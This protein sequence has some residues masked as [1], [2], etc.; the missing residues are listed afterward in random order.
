VSVQRLSVHALLAWS[1]IALLTGRPVSANPVI[2]GPSTLVGAAV[3]SVDVVAEPADTVAVLYDPTVVR[4]V[5]LLLSPENLEF[6]DANPSAEQYVPGSVVID[7]VR[8]DQVGIRYKGSLGSFLGCT[9]SEDPFD[10]TGRKTCLKL[11]MKLKFD[12]YVSDQRFL[13]VK[14]LLLHAMRSDRSMLGER[15][16]YSLFRQ[17]GIA[18][19]R[20]AHVRV[21]VNG[22]YAGVFLLVE[23]VDGQFVRSRF[24]EGG[25]GNLYKE[26]WPLTA[27]PDY[28]RDGLRTNR[29]ENPS[30][31]RMVAFDQDIQN[32]ANDAAEYWLDL[33]YMMRYMAVD[34][35]IW[36]DDGIIHFYCDGSVCG[37][38]NFFFY[39]EVNR[40]R[41]WLIPWD[42]DPLFF[43]GPN[44]LTPPGDWRDLDPD[45][46]PV[47]TLPGLPLTSLNPA[48]DPLIS[49]LARYPELY[50]AKQQEF[51]EGPFARIAVE[52]QLDVWRE[53]IRGAVAEAH[54]IDP[55]HIAV[56]DW[57]A[58]IASKKAALA[59]A[60]ASLAADI[61][62]PEVS[63]GAASLTAL[64]VILVLRH[65][66]RRAPPRRSRGI[67]QRGVGSALDSAFERS[68]PQ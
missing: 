28:Y 21:V 15:L 27:D 7:G 50:R 44:P 46:V 66:G 23:Q 16:A 37:N 8:F 41:L 53:L 48:C 32:D 61:A 33:D 4:T 5:E 11:S 3:G 1:T 68:T 20:S 18:A 12:E 62:L 67:P 51:L 31:D 13:G 60:R 22:T 36:N 29:A 49:A 56:A 25:Q 57:E 45:C 14:R 34:R 52:D 42:M 10:P 6:L 58:E 40:D 2:D 38:H 9:D 24:S 54:A 30:V 43:A 17:L 63:P 26:T 35:A 64:V 65:R 39:E 19:P 55:E 47:A 59:F